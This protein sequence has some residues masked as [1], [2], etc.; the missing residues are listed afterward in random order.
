MS[1]SGAKRLKI[2]LY[3]CMASICIAY[4]AVPNVILVKGNQRLASISLLSQSSVVQ[5]FLVWCNL[6]SSILS[7]SM[8]AHA[9]CLVVRLW[10]VSYLSDAIF[11]G[12]HLRNFET[13]PC[14]FRGLICCNCDAGSVRYHQGVITWWWKQRRSQSKFM[15]LLIWDVISSWE[16]HSSGM[17]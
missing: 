5:V 4:G 14:C 2:D 17:W 13:K 9:F 1:N 7:C 8:R 6:V 10:T 15:H 16:L 3:T 11:S 12:N